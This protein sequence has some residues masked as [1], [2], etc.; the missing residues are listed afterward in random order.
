MTEQQRFN[1]Y[2]AFVQE[3]SRLRWYIL[4]LVGLSVCDVLVTYM[5]LRASPN[6]YESNPLANW[7]FTKYDIAG[8]IFL[9]FAGVSLAVILAEYVE[10]HR[11]GMGKF[12]L[13]FGIGVTAMVAIYGLYLYYYVPH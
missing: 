8:M 5:L 7:L 12:I 10:H 11:A 9:K 1:W 2:R 13:I 3:V 6:F 4:T